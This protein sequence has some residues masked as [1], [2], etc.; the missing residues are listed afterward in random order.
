MEECRIS[1]AVVGCGLNI[2][3]TW[4]PEEINDVATSL[5]LLGAETDKAELLFQILRETAG[6]YPVFLEDP[7]AFLPEYRANCVTLGRRVRVETD[8]AFEGF[9]EGV[10]D[11]GDLL[12]R[13]ELG[14][15]RTCTSGEVSIRPT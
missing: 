9:A 7:T 4:F 11:L 12:I 8:P 14:N 1:Y 2:S 5:R 6:L 3:Q 13:T 10:S 15:L